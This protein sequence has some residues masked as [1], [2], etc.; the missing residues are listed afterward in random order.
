MPRGNL[1]G[2]FPRHLMLKEVINLIE[3][4]EYGVAFKLMRTHKID[5]NLLYDVNP[6]QF[7]DNIPKVVAELKSVDFLNLFIN[8]LNP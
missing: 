4:K 3:S 6:P 1:E 2:I 7:M 8:S 5:L